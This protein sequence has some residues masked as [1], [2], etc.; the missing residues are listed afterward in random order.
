[1]AKHHVTEEVIDIYLREIRDS[2]VD[3]MILGCTH[4]PLLRSAIMRYM[5]DRVHIV[6]PAYETAMDLK[7]VLEERGISRGVNDLTSTSSMSVMRQRNS[8]N[9]P[10]PYYHMMWE[11]SGRLISRTIRE[12]IR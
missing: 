12:S 11:R 1:M 2:E 4:Y 5:G 3:T 7:K 6:N 8:S 10:I 9:L